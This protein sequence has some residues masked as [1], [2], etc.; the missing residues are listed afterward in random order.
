M[1]HHHPVK[2]DNS[3]I[4]LLISTDKEQQQKVKLS[5]IWE[6]YGAST[7]TYTLSKM[8]AYRFWYPVEVLIIQSVKIYDALLW[9]D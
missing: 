1:T 9:K 5:R 7:D 8:D 3:R 6:K 4:T 2:S